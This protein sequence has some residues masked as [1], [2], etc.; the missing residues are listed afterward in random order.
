MTDEEEIGKALCRVFA[1][2][3]ERE[4]KK[5]I[6]KDDYGGALIASFIEGLFKEAEKS[7]QE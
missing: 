2:I 7:I 4:K 6:Q 3:A 1:E 5:A